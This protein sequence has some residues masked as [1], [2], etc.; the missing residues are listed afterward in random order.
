MDKAT[1][2]GFLVGF[3]SIIIS[4]LLG[5]PL[6]TFWDLPSVFIVAGGTMASLMINFS[7]KEVTSVMKVV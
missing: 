7:M 2:I 1:L 6:T 4:I 3:I 5:G